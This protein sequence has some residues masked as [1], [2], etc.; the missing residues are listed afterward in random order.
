MDTHAHFDSIQ[1]VREHLS[2]DESVDESLLSTTP[3]ETGVDELDTDV[4]VEK[5]TPFSAEDTE[6][7]FNG[8]QPQGNIEEAKESEE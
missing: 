4:N 3:I 7:I 8:E 5:T 6:R 2:S 1:A